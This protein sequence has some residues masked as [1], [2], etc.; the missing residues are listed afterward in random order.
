MRSGQTIKHCPDI[1]LLSHVLPTVQAYIETV[2]Q[3]DKLVAL[4]VCLHKSADSEPKINYD[5]H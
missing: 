3:S 5:K 1:A 2:L 4:I